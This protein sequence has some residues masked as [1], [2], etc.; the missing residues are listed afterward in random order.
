MAT[1]GMRISVKRC[2]A[3]LAAWDCVGD[4]DAV[5]EDDDVDVVV[6]GIDMGD[7][8]AVRVAVVETVDCAEMEFMLMARTV[9]DRRKVEVEVLE[10]RQTADMDRENRIIC[11]P[12]SI[13]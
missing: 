4:G 12:W 8:E 13:S 7:M 9:M 11:D 3:A 2:P 5:V 6:D 10:R 1:R